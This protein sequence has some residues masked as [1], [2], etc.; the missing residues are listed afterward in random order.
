MTGLAISS[1]LRSA[2]PWGPGPIYSDRSLRSKATASYAVSG[3][4]AV[5]VTPDK[6]TPAPRGAAD[7][8]KRRFRRV[9][10]V[11]PRRREG[12]LTEL[13]AGAQP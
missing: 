3:P 6:L 12:R 8:W 5:K 1:D 9:S 10:P 13:K 11:A 2:F 7:D 4:T